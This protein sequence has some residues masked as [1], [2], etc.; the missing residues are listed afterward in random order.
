MQ[1]TG[2]PK[3]AGMLFAHAERAARAVGSPELRQTGPNRVCMNRRGRTLPSQTKRQR[4]HVSR[5]GPIS[6]PT[7]YRPCSSSSAGLA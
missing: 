6:T 4:Q 1:E 5:K 2:K 7:S 3:D